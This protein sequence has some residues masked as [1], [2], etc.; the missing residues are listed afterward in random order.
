MPQSKQHK[1]SQVVSI[2]FV[3]I[4]SAMLFAGATQASKERPK[5]YVSGT[6]DSNTTWTLEQSPYLVEGNIDINAG[7][8]LTI[9]AGVVVKFSN[10]GAMN[11]YGELE[12]IGN[13]ASPIHFTDIR[14]S[15]VGG[16]T[17]GGT[18]EPGGW[19]G[20]FI[21]DGG[22]ATL[23]YCDIAYAYYGLS[24]AGGAVQPV[25]TTNNHYHDNLQGVTLDPGSSYD[26]SDSTFADNGTDVYVNSG[27][28]YSHV[29]WNVNPAA[30]VFLSGYL[31]IW[32]EASL[33]IAPGTVVKSAV[34]GGSLN[35]YGE[36]LAQGTADARIHFT[37]SRDATVGGS[38]ETGT[39]EAGGWPGIFIYDGG[40]ATLAY[41]DIAYAY[42]GL[43]I[44]GGAVQPVST[45]HN[46]YHDNLQGVTLDPGSSYDDADSTFAD[47][48][49]DVYVN[50]GE[51]YSHVTWNVN[52][53]A[54]V[55]LSG[56]LNI[57]GE[58]S[59]TITPG[60]VVKS[61]VGS[62]SLHIY[63]ELLAQ[64]TAD[65]RIHFTDNRDATVGG[66]A[67]AGTPEAGGWS[68]IIIYDGGSALLEQCVISYAI[69]GLFMSDITVTSPVTGCVFT[70]NLIGISAINM[71]GLI[72]R[73]NQFLENT[74]YGVYNYGTPI[75]DAR[76][77]WWGDASGPYHPSLNSQGQGDQV[78]DLVLFEDWYTNPSGQYTITTP[79]DPVAGGS[80]TG[81]GIYSHG[82]IV[83]LI[84]DAGVGYNFTNW[85]EN[86]Q[87]IS[88]N[89]LYSF[90]ANRDRDI[91]ANFVLKEYPV[92]VSASPPAGDSASGGGIY[93]H[94]QEITVNA[95]P[96]EGYEFVNWKEN[97]SVVSTSPQYTF[98]VS[99]ARTLT[100]TFALKQY[101]IN[102]SASPAMGGAVSGG[103]VYPHFDAVTVTASAAIGYDFVHWTENSQ[104]VS[105]EPQYMFTVTGARDLT[106]HFALKEY[107]VNVSALPVD[108]GL[109]SGSGTYTHGQEITVT[110]TAAEG[111]AFVHW[112][113]NAEV[114]SSTAQYTFTA[115]RDRTLAAHFSLRE[116]AVV[117]SANPENG[118]TV[119][120]SGNYQHGQEVTV[121]AHA[122]EGYEF[123][124]WTENTET[125]STEAEY[126]FTATGQ[127][128]LTAHFQ[129]HTHPADTNQDWRIGIGEAIAYLAGWQQGSNPIGYAI[130]AAYL[131]QNGETYAYDGEIAPPLCWILKQ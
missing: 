95:S 48:G 19:S 79:I 112:T 103:G 29:T 75:V 124:R 92:E 64:G 119:T 60:T 22:T 20:I 72:L 45:T 67:E 125:V 113:E 13:Q 46:H 33:A 69:N 70:Q 120:G 32:V 31:N 58:S 10:N 37:D 73:N 12:T 26:D 68:G 110:A 2:G 74:D 56:Y 8:R 98:T 101:T 129:S 106:A 35:I 14:D 121:T 16:S 49:T 102:A 66:S 83:T 115:S 21:Y 117:L 116:Y 40:T 88:T 114:V 4:M 9:A 23:A 118:G 109:V 57:W 24:I 27:E 7:I 87:V 85:S 100:A 11:V 126:S 28:C 3:F 90:V 97:D 65:A 94:F 51:C 41:C 111:Y 43:S 54:T 34:N 107:T 122:N 96:A 30:T 55:F 17:G 123:V 52:P 18:P 63:G 105:T 82:D 131:W 127:R 42:Y 61:A 80:A 36:L 15:S 89:P 71:T 50:S 130:R 99:G 6:I 53:A 38:A 62:G 93:Q 47:N 59:L 78:S 5:T 1:S 104:I 77:N 108:G 81:A 84:A 25:S 128:V 44:A 39:P 91:T 76:R 86:A